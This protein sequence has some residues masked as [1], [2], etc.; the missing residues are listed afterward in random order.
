ML[1]TLK[2]TYW[3]LLKLYLPS[4]EY[5]LVAMLTGESFQQIQS[6]HG[7]GLFIGRKYQGPDPDP[8]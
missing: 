8:A 5:I 1:N 4:R 2:C 7:E 3:K 6:L